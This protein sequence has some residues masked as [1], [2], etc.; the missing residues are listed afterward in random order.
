MK[1]L[2]FER[3]GGPPEAGVLAPGESE[4]VPLHSVGFSC[5]YSII[6]GGAAALDRVRAAA[7]SVPARIAL[8]TVRILAPIHRPPKF[9]CIGL[10]YR[11]HAIE[12]NMA[13]P[14]IPTVFNKFPNTV[15]GP[16]DKIVLPKMSSQPDYEAEFAF[17][18]G[19]TG[20]RISGE[21]WRDYVFGYTNVNDVSARDIQLKGTTQ[22]LMGKTFDTFAPMGPYIVTADEIPDPHNLNIK[23][24][25]N[26]EVMQNSSTK[27]LIFNI[28]QLL[29]HLS[30]VVTLEPGDIVSTGTPPGVGMAKKPN[31]VFLKPGDHCIVEVEGLGQLHNPVV[32]EEE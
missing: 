12:S 25:L 4:I 10:N 19:K 13:I 17:V 16:M 11:D 29:E 6:Q 7:S 9:I 22:W 2:M 18:I 20:K 28:P 24:T 3:P 31:P 14:E 15:I 8:D 26:G 5:V 27:E 21:N 23:L 30:K 32:G 1:L